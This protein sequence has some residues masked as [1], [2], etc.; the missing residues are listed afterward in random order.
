MKNIFKLK[1]IYFLLVF[2]LGILGACDDNEEP[3]PENEEEE[4]T[5]LNLTFTPQGGGTVVNASW[6]DL[7]GDGG[8]APE[9]SDITLEN[10]KTYLLEIE[11]L[12]ENETP[13]EDITEEVKEE[14]AEHQFFYGGTA[15]FTNYINVAYA[16]KESDYPPNTGDNPVGLKGTI[17]SIKAGN[18]T[19][20]I[21][22]KHE[23]DKDA[24]GVSDGDIT[25][26]GG[27]TDID[28]SFNMTIQ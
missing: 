4:I 17:S 26:S 7:D 24:T 9:I 2:S 21:V 19:F 20:Q 16:D 8:N 1:H 23:P 18:G 3:E 25:L 10:N 13:A 15:V 22:L 12:N 28:V 11:L 14:A 27:E 5:T 6:K